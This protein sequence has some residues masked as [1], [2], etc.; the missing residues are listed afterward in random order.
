MASLPCIS[1]VIKGHPF[2][3][4]GNYAFVIVSVA[5]AWQEDKQHV[6]ETAMKK[7]HEKCQQHSYYIKPGIFTPG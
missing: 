5:G 2:E 3:T 7:A 4:N 1:T 6:W